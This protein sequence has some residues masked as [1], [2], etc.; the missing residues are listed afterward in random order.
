MLTLLSPIKN[1]FSKIINQISSKVIFTFFG[2]IIL[3]VIAGGY[4]FYQVQTK[5]FYTANYQDLEF[6]ARF[7]IDQ[8]T[9]W[10]DERLS[11][12]IFF[13]SN[14][15]I[16]E[17]IKQWMNTPD[18]LE[19]YTK[20]QSAIQ[21]LKD[22]Y[23]YDSV[24][25]TS[26]DGD[27]LFTTDPSIR[28]MEPSR[29]VFINQVKEG[30]S[31][32]MG[33]FYRS[34]LDKKVYIDFSAP[35]RDDEMQT[36][37][38]IIIRV[39]PMDYIYPLIQSW[40]SDSQSGE[41]LLIRKNGDNVEFLNS[42]RHSDA[43]PL[44]LF[45]P[46][47]QTN[48][49]AARAVLGF[50]GPFEGS[51]YRGGKV[52]SQF[53]PIPET[54]WYI[55]S[56]IDSKEVLDQ[57]KKLGL[58]VSLV[59][60]FSILCTTA[61][62]ALI[63][64]YRQ[65]SLY[66]KILEAER[67]AQLEHNLLSETL[68][69][70]MNEIYLFDAQSLLFRAVNEGALKNL[71]YSHD[72]MLYMTPLDIKPEINQDQF[73]ALIDPLLEGNQD[74]VVFETIHERIDHS[75][76]PVDVHLQIVDIGTD[77]VFLAVIQDITERKMNEEKLKVS[78][79]KYRVLFQTFPFGV[80]V[81]DQ[82][83][84]IVEVNDESSRLLELP[85]EVILS[86]TY[87]NPD[88]AV[89]HKDGSPMDPAEYP[90]SQALKTG[91]LVENVEMGIR[92]SNDR[93]VWINSAAAPIPLKDYGVLILMADISERVRMENELIDSEERYRKLV[94]NSPDAI[95]INRNDKIEYM[96]TAGLDLFGAI[97]SSE[98]IGKSPIELFHPD[99]HE[100]V[101]QR[102]ELMLIRDEPA[103]TIQ[104]KII[105]LDGSI[106]DVEVAATPFRDTTGRAIQVILRDI[107]DRKQ[108]EEK[109]NEQIDELRRWHQVTLGR[110]N[111]IMEM[112]AEINRLLQTLGLPE[113]YEEIT[114]PKSFDEEKID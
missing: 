82:A 16:K 95:F 106:R 35:I 22:A 69:A 15:I 81:T 39:N 76:Y 113:R 40:P 102:I 97:D 79:E 114:T 83:G 64:I 6:V 86:R 43:P 74:L 33:D 32:M 28:E 18:N 84:K 105:C 5:S 92:L 54:N 73:T 24:Q 65:R 50:T 44:S 60:I 96:N 63:I 109:L 51:D 61:S 46:I 12:A 90:S 80:M 23:S 45:F 87:D 55:V 30:N 91:N 14:P 71:G 31:T 112:K 72:Q 25:I 56:K 66:Q 29:L 2:I 36:F 37:A 11:D 4:R 111:R 8:I 75:R 59:V 17:S 41:T 58:N 67:S 3:I 48:L 88:W 103:P 21:L 101:K 20:I 89:I 7:K 94:E 49:P 53:Y 19:Y 10:R 1:N 34:T 70:S 108:A 100:M 38:M 93:V 47:T 42:L 98:I 62:V 9:Q 107:T 110:E 52:L 78:F 77:R 68:N 57:I 27:V 104:E 26:T 85:K 13:S 99:F